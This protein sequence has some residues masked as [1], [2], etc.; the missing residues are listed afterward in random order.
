[1]PMRHLSV[2]HAK[3]LGVYTISPD[4]TLKSAA[5]TMQNHNIS[6]L[7]VT[8]ADGSLAGVITRTDMVRACYHHSE[9]S[10]LPVREFMAPDV[11]TV[12]LDD[13]LAKVMELLIDHHIHRVVAVE[14][15]GDKVRPVAVLSAADIVYHMTKDK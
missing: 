1:M 10:M 15:H 13:K 7:V 11:V 3:R 9:W 4:E 2:L 14:P 8:E 6:A 12:H 5:Q